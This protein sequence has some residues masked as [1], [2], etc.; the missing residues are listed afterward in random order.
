MFIREGDHKILLITFLKVC[1]A[2]EIKYECRC[3]SFI[4]E[5]QSFKQKLND[6]ELTL[7]AKEE[8]T[9]KQKNKQTNW[10]A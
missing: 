2:D 1:I 6:N 3:D 10:S 5:Y 7:E 9:N 8:N 4:K